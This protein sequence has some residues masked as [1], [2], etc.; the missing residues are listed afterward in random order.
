MDRLDH[1]GDL[2]LLVANGDID[3]LT[4]LIGRTASLFKFIR[5]LRVDGVWQIPV[6]W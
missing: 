3:D 1:D 2:E 6:P 4:T 5:R